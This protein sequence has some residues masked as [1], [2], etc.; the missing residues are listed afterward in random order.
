MASCTA[1][2]LCPVLSNTRPPPSQRPQ[3]LCTVRERPT[4]PPRPVY[5]NVSGGCPGSAFEGLALCVIGAAH[6]LA[7][8]GALLGDILT[9]YNLSTF[10]VLH[11]AAR[12]DDLRGVYMH[13]I[14][15][16]ARRGRT[17]NVTRA[18]LTGVTVIFSY[19]LT[20]SRRYAL[21]EQRVSDL[22]FFVN[23]H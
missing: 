6:R 12:R 15:I 8:R 7:W 1:L 21:S 22:D 16:F 18:T 5:C 9:I 19:N 14:Q 13:S 20:L 4:V 23:R 3:A 10:Y 11:R 2:P 17:L